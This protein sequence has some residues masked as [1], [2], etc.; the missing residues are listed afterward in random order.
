MLDRLPPE[1]LLRILDLDNYRSS[2]SPASREESERPYLDALRACTLVCMNASAVARP[3]LWREV[4]TDKSYEQYLHLERMCSVPSF[5]SIAQLV[6][7]LEWYPSAPMRLIEPRFD[8]LLPVLSN[9]RELRVFGESV[10]IEP[11]MLPSAAEAPLSGPICRTLVCARS[12]TS[13]TYPH[14][15]SAHVEIQLASHVLRGS[16]SSRPADERDLLPCL[17]TIFL[18]AYFHRLDPSTLSTSAQQARD[19][20]FAQCEKHKVQVCY[21]SD[22]GKSEWPEWATGMRELDELVE[23]E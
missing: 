10:F 7:V 22:E 11:D 14:F 12:Q 8:R 6:R 23:A 19:D 15:A 20:F 13:S 21:L 3:E 18:P 17:E 9:L 1:L 2:S 16:S 4:S 5:A